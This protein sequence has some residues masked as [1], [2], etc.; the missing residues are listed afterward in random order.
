M[1]NS[2]TWVT[3]RPCYER[4]YYLSSK[5]SLDPSRLYVKETVDVSATRTAHTYSVSISNNASS[6]LTLTPVPSTRTG[7]DR[8]TL[9]G[10]LRYPYVYGNSPYDWV[11]KATYKRILR[12]GDFTYL[13]SVDT[14]GAI[15][16]YT[17]PLSSFRQAR[18]S[19]IYKHTPEIKSASTP[20][21]TGQGQYNY[22]TVHGGSG[23]W[24]V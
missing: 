20:V 3:R 7:E 6:I 9:K 11:D 4:Y 2:D 22:V 19:E 17:I 23:P 12:P 13:P 16:A 14:E 15:A 8:V 21:Q 1:R 24:Y 18:D 10:D 5:T